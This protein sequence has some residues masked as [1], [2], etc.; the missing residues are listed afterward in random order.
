MIIAATVVTVIVG[1]LSTLQV[2]AVALA[3]GIIRFLNSLRTKT[4]P[5]PQ[6]QSEPIQEPVATMP[7]D[8]RLYRQA[9]LNRVKAS[10]VANGAILIVGEE[11]SGKSVLGAAV[12]ESLE[13]DGFAIAF[14]E[15]A[16]PKP[17]L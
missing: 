4:T 9:E 2:V 12:V 15:P 14:V 8:K 6:P 1:R 7:T 13:E 16:T 3:G 5:A 10:L 11:G 17:K